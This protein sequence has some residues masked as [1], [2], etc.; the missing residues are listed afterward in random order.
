MLLLASD[1]V[2]YCARNEGISSQAPIYPLY[3]SVALSALFSPTPDAGE[4]FTEFFIA[5]IPRCLEAYAPLPA[6][7]SGEL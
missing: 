3:G 6:N 2:S 1:A 4:R 7:P 5:N